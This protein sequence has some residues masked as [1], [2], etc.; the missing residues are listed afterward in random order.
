MTDT[1][2]PEGKLSLAKILFRVLG[3]NIKDSAVSK[4]DSFWSHGRRS[5]I[6]A[7]NLKKKVVTKNIYINK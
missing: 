6:S 5:D 4:Q 7:F 2:P 3:N 1:F